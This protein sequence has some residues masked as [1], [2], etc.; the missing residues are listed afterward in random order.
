M[1]CRDDYKKMVRLS[2]QRNLKEAYSFM[3]NDYEVG[4]FDES[5]EE[6]GRK[7]YVAVFDMNDLLKNIR[8]GSILNCECIEKKHKMSEFL[9]S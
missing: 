9:K 6:V 2:I 5:Q 8:Q 1:P 7:R 3:A 4:I